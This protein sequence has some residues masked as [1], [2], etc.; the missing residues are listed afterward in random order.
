MDDGDSW[1]RRAFAARETAMTAKDMA[2]FRIHMDLANAYELR[3]IAERRTSLSQI[4]RETLSEA[5]ESPTRGSSLA[6][7]QAAQQLRSGRRSR[8][9]PMPL[10]RN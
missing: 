2:N 3:L 6:Q 8:I 1:A 5:G 10:L 4:P 7:E 9:G